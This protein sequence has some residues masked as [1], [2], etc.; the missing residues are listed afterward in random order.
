MTPGTISSPWIYY[1]Q[2]CLW[3]GL[4][5]VYNI[6]QSKALLTDDENV[7]DYDDEDE[8]QNQNGEGVGVSAI[9]FRFWMQIEE[10]PRPRIL[11]GILTKSEERQ[12]GKNQHEYPLSEQDELDSGSVDVLLIKVSVSDPDEPLDSHRAHN[13]RCDHSNAYHDERVV[14]AKPRATHPPSI[15]VHRQNRHRRQDDARQI[16]PR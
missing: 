4:F 12:W 5:A 1:Y 11:P 6:I 3:Q 14:V 9:Q 7:A 16:S 2:N 15:H 10:A 13:T 8:E